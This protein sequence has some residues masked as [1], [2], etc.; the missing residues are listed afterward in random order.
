MRRGEDVE[1]SAAG[2]KNDGRHW[3][4]RTTRPFSSQLCF[5]RYFLL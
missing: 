4:F 2:V 1:S 3:R 5:S